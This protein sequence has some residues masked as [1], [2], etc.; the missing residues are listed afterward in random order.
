MSYP[1]T[2]SSEDSD[3]LREATPWNYFIRLCNNV[4]CPHSEVVEKD[5]HDGLRKRGFLVGWG[6]EMGRGRLGHIGLVYTKFG[7]FCEYSHLFVA[8]A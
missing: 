5:I 7:G 2:R 6:E 1:P 4:I 8:V 3:L